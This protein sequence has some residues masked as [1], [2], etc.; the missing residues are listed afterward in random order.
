MG[1][2]CMNGKS[3][4]CPE[5]ILYE[6]LFHEQ[7]VYFCSYNLIVLWLTDLC[8]HKELMDLKVFPHC[9]QSYDIPSKCVS[10]CLSI[11]YLCDKL[12]LQTL[13]MYFPSTFSVC[14]LIFI[15]ISFASVSLIVDTIPTFSLATS[16]SCSCNSF[17]KV[18]LG[19]LFV[20]KSW[21][22]V[23]LVIFVRT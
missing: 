11:L 15:C 14:S 4:F 12:L 1:A 7:W 6:T 19:D 2:G 8:F 13:H 17:L 10:T 16:C 5:I 20:S 23:Q 18:F 22:K 3:I 21:R 9:W